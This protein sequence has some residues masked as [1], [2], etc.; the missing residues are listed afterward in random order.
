M[1]T[2]VLIPAYNSENTIHRVLSALPSEST[3]PMVIVNGST[4]ATAEIARSF[5]AEVHELEAKVKMPAIQFGIRRLGT[6]ALE[7]TLLID[8]DTVPAFPSL[9][10]S[11]MTRLLEGVDRPTY[12][13]GPAWFTKRPQGS[14]LDATV[15]S[16]GR[17][18]DS[19]R[20]SQKDIHSGRAAY[21]G[22]N[23]GFALHDRDTLNRIL[24]LP[25]YWPKE[26]VAFARAIV[27]DGE[28]IMHTLLD[29]RASV[30]TQA[31]DRFPHFIDWLRVPGAELDAR[32]TAEYRADAAEGS[33]PYTDETLTILDP[34]HTS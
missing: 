17:V 8:S 15:Y 14:R 26:D 24:D 33:I 7:P 29:P 1:K 20:R 32:I 9:W 3:E 11:R 6:K 12:V 2:P 25:H 28:G 4:D 13:S 16:V 31:S 34:P 30:M 19:I 18:V 10:E 22:P 23:Q 21:Y 27:H 5:G